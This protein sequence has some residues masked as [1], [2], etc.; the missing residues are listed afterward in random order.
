MTIILK[1]NFQY[2][3]LKPDNNDLVY[4]IESNWQNHNDNTNGIHYFLARSIPRTVTGIEQEEGD[5]GTNFGNGIT[6]T[7][8]HSLGLHKVISKRKTKED[9]IQTWLY[10]LEKVIN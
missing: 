9:F 2:N 1:I 8:S 5:L 6:Q 10:K 7:D 3:A 4:V